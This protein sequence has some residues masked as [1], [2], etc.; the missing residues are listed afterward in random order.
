MK[1]I[2]LNKI[3]IG[4]S[5]LGMVGITGLVAPIL[6]SC[7]NSDKVPTVPE[8]GGDG[9]KPNPVLPTIKFA[10][11]PQDVLFSTQSFYDTTNQTYPDKLPEGTTTVVRLPQVSTRNNF[12]IS[13]DLIKYKNFL[14]T[15]DLTT[16]NVKESFFNGYFQNFSYDNK[17]Y[18]DF[19]HIFNLIDFEVTIKQ[20]LD[21][22]LVTAK[23][24]LNGQ[25][26]KCNLKLISKKP[27]EFNI[28]G[29]A[30]YIIKLLPDQKEPTKFNNAP[31]YYNTV[32]P[33][34]PEDW[35]YKILGGFSESLINDGFFTNGNNVTNGKIWS[36]VLANSAQ[37]IPNII[38]SDQLIA[39]Y[40][41]MTQFN[42]F[43]TDN[44]K[45]NV[46]DRKRVEE[47]LKLSITTDRRMPQGPLKYVGVRFTDW[48][49]GWYS[50]FYYLMPGAPSSN[51]VPTGANS[52]YEY[53]KFRFPNATDLD[54]QRDFNLKSLKDKG[55]MPNV[56]EALYQ[57]SII[58]IKN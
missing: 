44:V 39:F 55:Y 35:Y 49:M 42:I 11:Q 37:N 32:A 19:S 2:K 45:F 54:A 20:R 48:P 6:V 25:Y 47:D 29:S 13:N 24:D 56:D 22:N 9:E 31:L 8:G 28:E 17:T 30:D 51:K 33:K 36:S 26:I 27:T 16:S 34:D 18:T 14:I 46:I 58:I 38:S 10:S 57:E 5:I 7:G 52:F 23:E 12:K 41:Y 21:S 3:K 1:K 50:S 43:E 53:I 15:E 4:L 40:S